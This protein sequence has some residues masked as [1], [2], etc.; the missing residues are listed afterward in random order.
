MYISRL[1][2]D[3]D[4]PSWSSFNRHPVSLISLAA[5]LDLSSS[6]FHLSY[7]FSYLTSLVYLLSVYLSG[8]AVMP[9]HL[10]R[11]PSVAIPSV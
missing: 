4:T 8:S 3:Q 10:Q 11:R 9:S 7:L 5:C 1:V 2:K 6:P